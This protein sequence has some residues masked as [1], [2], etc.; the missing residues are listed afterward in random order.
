MVDAATLRGHDRRTGI[1]SEIHF[2][3]ANLAVPD[4]DFRAPLRELQVEP[5][6]W[7][8]GARWLGSVVE[9]VHGTRRVRIGIL[10][11]VPMREPLGRSLGGAPDILLDATTFA[12][13]RERLEGRGPYR[14]EGEDPLAHLLPLWP[15][16]SR[17]GLA[18]KL[19]LLS[20]VGAAPLLALWAVPIAGIVLVGASLPL[21]LGRRAPLA[22]TGSTLPRAYLCCHEGRA[23]LVLAKPEGLEPTGPAA[24]VVTKALRWSHRGRSR[25]ALQ[26]RLGERPAIFLAIE[27]EGPPAVRRDAAEIP[28]P[29]L[30]ISGRDRRQL[31]EG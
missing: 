25:P 27:G 15:I 4:R 28:M 12:R 11:Y 9:L 22:V 26:L 19:L 3:A 29:A 17:G 20:A 16:Q 13:L 30:W 2:D 31:G 7:M 8:D 1:V 23:R 21:V 14:A 18:E 24:P 10:G 5:Q 6:R